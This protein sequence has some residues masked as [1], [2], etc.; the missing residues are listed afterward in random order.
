MFSWEREREGGGGR[1]EEGGGGGGGGRRRGRKRRKRERGGTGP[2]PIT[3]RTHWFKV[4][5]NDPLLV[6]ELEAE[7]EGVSEPPDEREAEPLEAVLLD[8]L[9]KVHTA[10]GIV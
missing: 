9:I 6:Q 4:A 5:V 2:Q 10:T 7:E 3:M 8:Q 1:E